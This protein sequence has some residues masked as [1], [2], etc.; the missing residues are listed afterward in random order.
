MASASNITKEAG[1]VLRMIFSECFDVYDENFCR[2]VNYH[3]PLTKSK[4]I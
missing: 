3:F 2:T 1:N 4:R